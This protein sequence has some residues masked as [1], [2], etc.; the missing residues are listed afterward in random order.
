[1][2]LA[3]NKTNTYLCTPK[4]KTEVQNRKDYLF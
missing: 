3:K 1:V 2:S 4:S